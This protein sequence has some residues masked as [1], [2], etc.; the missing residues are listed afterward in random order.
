MR[1]LDCLI[2]FFLRGLTVDLGLCVTDDLVHL[3]FQLVLD[4]VG[5]IG[6]VDLVLRVLSD[7]IEVRLCIV[8][9]R[10]EDSVFDLLLRVLDRLID[11]FLRGLPVDLALC[12]SYDLIDF[13]FQIIL[14]IVGKIGS[15]DLVLCVLRDL[16]KV[17]LRIVLLCVEDGVRNLVLCVLDGL[18]HVIEVG[19]SVD[20][21]LRSIDNLINL[22]LQILLHFVGQ[23]RGIDLV[24]CV[25]SNVVKIGLC[26]VLV[27]IKRSAVDYTAHGAIA[28]Y[29]VVLCKVSVLNAADFALCKFDA[30]RGAAAVVGFVVDLVAAAAFMPMRGAVRRPLFGPV[31]AESG[32]LVRSR[33]GNIAAIALCGLRAVLGTRCIVVRNI[34]RKAVAERVNDFLLAAQFF[35]A[36]GAVHDFVIR[37]DHGTGSVH[38]IL[39]DSFPFGMAERGDLFIRRI[40]TTRAS[41]IGVPTDP[42]TRCSLCIVMLQVMAECFS[43]CNAADVAFRRVGARRG[44]A[45]VAGLV[46]DLVATAA[47]MPMRGAVRYPL[48]GPVMAESLNGLL[49]AAQFFAADGTVN[50]LVIRTGHGASSCHFVLADSLPFGMAERGDLFICRIVTTRAGVV[51]I[52]SD[53]GARCGLSIVML[54]VMA[55]CFSICNAADVAFRRV[56]ASRGA[57]AV[58]GLAVDLVAAAAFMPMRGAVRCPLFGP[59]MAE[60]GA[61][62]CSRVGDFAAIALCGL[63]SVLNTR[64]I[65]V[66]NIARK[67]MAECLNGFLLAAQFFTADGAVNDLV[68]RAGH[69]AA[70]WY[71]I[72]ADSLTFGMTER[73]DLHIRRIVATGTGVIR[74][75]SD[76]GTRC[77]FCFVMLKIM[78]E[79]FERLRRSCDVFLPAKH[80]LSVVGPHPFRFAFGGRRY[81]ARDRAPGCSCSL[82]VATILTGTS[83]RCRCRRIIFPRPIGLAVLMTE[84]LAMLKNLF[85]SLAADR[86]ALVVGCLSGTRC[87]RDEIPFFR[88]LH[89][90]VLCKVAV[91]CAADLALCMSNARRGAAAVI[92]LVVDL[93][94]ARALVPM[95]GAVCRPLY[96]PVMAKRGTIVRSR[97][98]D[99]AAIALCGLR[100]VLGTSCVVV[101]SIACKAVPEGLN[102]LLFTAQFFAADGTVDDLVIRAGH[103]AGSVHFVL[104]DSFPFGM[105]ERRDLLIRCIVTT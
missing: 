37:A 68:I 2:D 93:V 41:V 17:R 12:V 49:L 21:I 15:I 57:A 35:A 86:A 70:C 29:I 1:I 100:A 22:V 3:V 74:F 94:A 105:A 31:M 75:P 24:L 87:L 59:V 38:F 97:V 19:R 13:A 34:A 42:G 67:A 11:L 18:I 43:I 66:R 46:V 65:V 64:C 56:G 51:S 78:A 60:S 83:K 72:L 79:R 40:F 82:L 6:G 73:F 76:L 91:L 32:T 48:F 8:F 10:I 90:D 4:I 61:F 30:R 104:A 7:L 95:R 88:V 20:F 9:L 99:F 28:I 103:G 96:G 39:A 26:I 80:D 27:V 62:I 45:A 101:R 14:D 5:K 52:P 47:F 89:I 53:L 71:F 50:D 98:G 33:V 63:R 54:Q 23:V 81:D 92:C 77:R 84:G 69:G 25:L 16:I 102:G 55:E 58:V 36:D 85:S 44:T